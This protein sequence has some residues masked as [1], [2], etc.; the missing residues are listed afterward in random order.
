MGSRQARADVVSGRGSVP[1]VGGLAGLCG[2]FEG[3]QDG[4]GSH[5]TARAGLYAITQ[6]NRLT[7]TPSHSPT[8]AGSAGTAPARKTP[9]GRNTWGKDN[10]GARHSAHADDSGAR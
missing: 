10:R 5:R 1:R 7:T 3:S 2:D 9:D 4:R 6:A 8:A